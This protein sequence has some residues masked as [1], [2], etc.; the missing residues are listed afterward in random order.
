[1]N[2]KRD[3]LIIK[4]QLVAESLF[5]ER[6]N[7][8]LFKH[9]DE[10][11][12]KK[13]FL[14]L[15]EQSDDENILSL[16]TSNLTTKEITAIIDNFIKLQPSKDLYKKRNIFEIV[17]ISNLP[18]TKLQKILYPQKYKIL[19]QKILNVSCETNLI[20]L[21]FIALRIFNNLILKTDNLEVINELSKLKK[22]ILERMN[23]NTYK[24]ENNIKTNTLLCWIDL[25]VNLTLEKEIPLKDYIKLNIKILSLTIKNIDLLW[26]ITASTTF[27][28][29]Q[30]DFCDAHTLRSF[31]RFLNKQINQLYTLQNFDKNKTLNIMIDTLT[32]PTVLKEDYYYLFDSIKLLAQQTPDDKLYCF[33]LLWYLLYQDKKLYIF[34]QRF[35]REYFL[36]TLFDLIDFQD[37][38][39]IKIE[40][41]IFLVMLLLDKDFF[42]LQQNDIFEKAINLLQN[43][44]NKNSKITPQLFYKFCDMLDYLMD[45]KSSIKHS[46]I[47]SFLANEKRTVKTLGKHFQLYNFKYSV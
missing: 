20:S 16:N 23:K 28:L 4:K 27:L 6:K 1:M 18:K 35:I 26:K 21:D 36:K 47:L 43:F 3:I 25:L 9:F 38:L 11:I 8:K 10:L 17:K 45:K 30:P 5:K 14:N 37:I 15:R 29:N 31:K 41:Y 12:I 34:N 32:K 19:E 2:N 22:N 33:N 46:S 44:N 24:P 40:E 39:E 42:V 7:K 13:C